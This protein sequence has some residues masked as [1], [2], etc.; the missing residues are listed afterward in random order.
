MTSSAKSEPRRR[1]TSFSMAIGSTF[2]GGIGD[3]KVAASANPVKLRVGDPLTLTLEVAGSAGSGSLELMGTAVDQLSD[4]DLTTLRLTKPKLFGKP[5][6][7]L[8]LVFFLTTSVDV[9]NFYFLLFKIK[10]TN[11]IALLVFMISFLLLPIRIPKS[12]CIRPKPKPPRLFRLVIIE[13]DSGCTG[14]WLMF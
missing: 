7:V 2:T 14:A 10:L 4:S 13:G 8:L 11:V 1:R 3:Y 6:F 12:I 5:L 9:F